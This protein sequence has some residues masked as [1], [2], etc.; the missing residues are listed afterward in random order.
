MMQTS[1]VAAGA[2]TAIAKVRDSALHPCYVCVIA[3]AC[4]VAEPWNYCW[5]SCQGKQLLRFWTISFRTDA[6]DQEESTALVSELEAL[7]MLPP[8]YFD[9]I[10]LFK[11]ASYIPPHRVCISNPRTISASMSC[12]SYFKLMPEFDHSPYLDGYDQLYPGRFSLLRATR[13][14]TSKK[15]ELCHDSR[16]ECVVMVSPFSLFAHRVCIDKH[17]VL[18]SSLHPVKIT[19]CPPVS[20]RRN[21]GRPSEQPSSSVVTPEVIWTSYSMLDSELKL[22]IDQ[23]AT[24]E[25]RDEM[26][27]E[28]AKEAVREFNTKQHALRNDFARDYRHASDYQLR[29][30]CM[31][32]DAA[33]SEE[34]DAAKSMPDEDAISPFDLG[35]SNRMRRLWT[36]R[37]LKETYG[38]PLLE[39][40]GGFFNSGPAPF[41]IAVA[42]SKIF[43]HI[44][45]T[46]LTA[47]ERKDYK[48]MLKDRGGRPYHAAE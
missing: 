16:G 10:T 4:N 7:L 6:S 43:Q 15:C 25:G 36:C 23:V 46:P 45:K 48:E 24:Y 30:R 28:E 32:L 47:E 17:T 35:V 2:S 22:S 42:V 37:L 19:K 27:A 9:F 33:L 26:T 13:I 11:V 1:G 8:D 34:Y 3:Y 18:S 40:L 38:Q 44:K 41:S 5:C 31:L 20:L 21:P 39:D 12:E 29:K 14:L